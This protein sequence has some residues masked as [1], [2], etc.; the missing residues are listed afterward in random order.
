MVKLP[1]TLSWP[2]TNPA[3]VYLDIITGLVAPFTATGTQQG[4]AHLPSL[5]AAH[6]VAQ[7]AS[8]EIGA[9]PSDS[10]EVRPHGDCWKW[11]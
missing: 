9:L 4:P 11:S 1:C 2:Q 8:G 3:D 10:D 5:W 6:C 7:H